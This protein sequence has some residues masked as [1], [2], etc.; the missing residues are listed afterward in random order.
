[1]L[2]AE[3]ALGLLRI[4]Q[5]MEGDGEKAPMVHLHVQTHGGRQSEPGIALQATMFNSLSGYVVEIS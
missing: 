5:T 2:H 4:P 3:E 1:M